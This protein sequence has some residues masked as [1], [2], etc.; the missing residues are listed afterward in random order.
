LFTEKIEIKKAEMTDSE[1]ETRIK[2]KLNRFMQ[3]VD[4]VDVSD[5]SEQLH[6]A[7]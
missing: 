3:V 6:D 2:E 7:Q 5:V 1:L 4:V